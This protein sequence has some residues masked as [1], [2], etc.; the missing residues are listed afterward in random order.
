MS[1]HSVVGRSVTHGTPSQYA[2]FCRPA[3]VG[4]D[5]V[6]AGDEREHLE[7]AERLDRVD[8]RGE[9]EPVLVERVPRSR[10]HREDE[11]ALRPR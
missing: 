4:D 8:V 9:G 10:V 1:T 3:R 2:S 7:V 5:G 11:P 6:G